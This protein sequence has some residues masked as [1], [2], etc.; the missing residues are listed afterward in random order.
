MTQSLPKW[1]AITA[2]EEVGPSIPFAMVLNGVV[3]QVMFV[4]IPTASLLVEGPEFVRCSPLA[5][6]GMTVEE[7]TAN[8]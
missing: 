1:N 2:G 5:T 7:A 6:T 8:M 4:N 3:Q